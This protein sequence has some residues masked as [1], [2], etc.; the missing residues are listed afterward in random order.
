MNYASPRFLSGLSLGLVFALSG[1][2][3][4][5]PDNRLL[6]LKTEPDDT[7]I[8]LTG[9]LE[10]LGDG[11]I[12]ATP[13]D[14][15]ACSGEETVAPGSCEDV[16]VGA[17]AF[18][19]NGGT[20]VTVTQGENITFSWN[21]RGAWDC[22][23]GGNLPGWTHQDLLPR[24]LDDGRRTFNTTGL[25]STT[26]YTPTLVCS[27]GPVQSNDGIVQAVSVTVNEPT[28][29]PIEGCEE[30]AAPP[31]WTRMSTGTMSCI[32]L[33]SWVS[34]ADCRTWNPGVW[35]SDFVGT[36]GV[37]KRV[38]AG[39]ISGREYIAMEINT[40]GMSLTKTG[41]LAAESGG[42]G[43]KFERNITTIS[44]CPGDFDRNAIMAETGC[45][46]NLDQLTSLRWGGPSTTRSCKLQPNT[47]YFLNILFTESPNGTPTNEI[48]PHSNCGGS[49][50]ACGFVVAP[51]N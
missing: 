9:N 49:A 15:E 39:R 36:N 6:I 25:A 34:S 29:A 11:S 30:R 20:S 51:Y 16:A 17:P 41:E 23:A 21:S 32:Y 27:N 48:Q 10:I 45:Y 18:R 5:S 22:Q 7:V 14:L 42:S 19:V 8:E 3:A 40:N 13:V 26:A 2:F 12:Q 35:S 28:T 1:A 31:N 38:A 46:L 33:S 37:T 4:Q 50:G 43:P 47:R 44:T 24:S